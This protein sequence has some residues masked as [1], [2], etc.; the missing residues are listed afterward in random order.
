MRQITKHYLEVDG[1]EYQLC[2]PIKPGIDVKINRLQDG[3]II[4]G[5]LCYDDDCPDPLKN[6]DGMGTIYTD[7][8]DEIQTILDNN[9]DAMPVSYITHGGLCSWNICENRHNPNAVWV[10]D[11]TILES[12]IGQDGLSR[13][14]WMKKQADIVCQEYTSWC[15]GDCWGTIAAKYNPDGT[16]IDFDE[17]W[18]II[19]QEY[20]EAELTDVMSRM[21]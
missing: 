13:Y 5:Y 1:K 10:P 8:I 9:P 14:E 6:C 7:D 21:K 12:Y 17:C 3:S 2:Y 4:I 15:N 16:R 19:G 20:A 11:D 18:G